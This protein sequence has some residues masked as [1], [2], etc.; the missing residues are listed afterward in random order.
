MRQPP[1]IR[2]A[3]AL[4][5]LWG[6]ASAFAGQ[7]LA[8]A[9]PVTSSGLP[10]SVESAPLSEPGVGA[11]GLLRSGIT[12]LPPTLWKGSDPRSLATLIAA[13]ELPVPALSRLMH[14]LIL[15]EALPPEGDRQHAFLDSRLDWLM[16]QGAVD[17]ALALLDITGT[18]DPRLFS[19]WVDLSL[20][21]GDSEPVCKKLES[22]PRLSSDLSLRIFCTARAGD[23]QRAALIL[24][25][26]ET[27]GE[28][29][30]R[31]AEILRRFLDPDMGDG[32]TLL[33]P[34]RP[35]PLEFRLF[36]ALGEPLPT[37]PLPLP[38]A[39]LDLAGD[40]GWRAQIEAAE[41][42]ARAG[43]FSPN[44]LLGLY[45]LRRPA[46]SGGVWDRVAALQDFEAALERDKD[47]LIGR[48]LQKVW[49][50]MAHAR[51]LTPFAEL[52]A[53]RLAGR[54]LDGRAAPM[55]RRALFL[56]PDYEDLAQKG[57]DP[58]REAEFLAAIARGEPPAEGAAL[59]HADA[60]A[61][62]FGE[63]SVP[64]VLQAQLKEGRLGEVILRAMAL[65]ASGA[66]GNGQDLSDA[67]ATLRAVGLEDTARRASL[68]LMILDAERALQ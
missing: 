23:W 57:Q 15:A 60:V 66:A 31:H 36:E 3:A 17:E 5:L 11:A 12:G 2:H 54:K 34:V 18:D 53:D 35:T 19:D 65:F 24:Q 26:A 67:I 43:S 44:R 58:S 22:Q 7:A 42:L 10:P 9:E 37:A 51:L 46:A 63:A 25:S 16:A 41:R 32:R 6:G 45:T 30:G 14:T 55:A 50:Q 62:G 28:I 61:Q 48:A 8:Q 27:L 21:V 29:T 39:V 52:F 56:S 59:P 68:E 40:N 38:F 4:A 49:P 1:G 13:V 64:T 47:D 20:L 33:P